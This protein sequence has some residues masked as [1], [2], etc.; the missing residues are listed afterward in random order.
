[1]S[2]YSVDYSKYR[3]EKSKEDL[4]AARLLFKNQ[5]YGAANNRAYYC[6]FHA[7]RSVLALDRF[8]SKKHSS[9]IAKFR[10][11]YIKTGILPDKVSD[12][13]KETFEVRQDSDYGDM[14]EVTEEETATQI[15][16]AEYVYE[17]IGKYL[18]ER[19]NTNST[20]GEMP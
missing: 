9:V 7:I 18:K 17:T 1:M 19:W 4:D 14:Y 15:Q 20:D 13:I 10:E 12:A 6:V 2:D 3:Y 16:H 5:S 11:N 8:D